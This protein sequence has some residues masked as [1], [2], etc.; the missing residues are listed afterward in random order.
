MTTHWDGNWDLKLPCLTLPEA[1]WTCPLAGYGTWGLPHS[2]TPWQSRDDPV[3]T[4]KE[5]QK[6]RRQRLMRHEWVER[7]VHNI[8][9]FAQRKLQVPQKVLHCFFFYL[10]SKLWTQR[11]SS[12]LQPPLA[13]LSEP[14]HCSR[15]TLTMTRWPKKPTTKCFMEKENT[16]HRHLSGNIHFA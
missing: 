5:T 2:H 4:Q 10:L 15:F 6:E 9:V 8:T 14:L 11:Y 16:Q 13:L 1:P 12:V 7:K 3:V